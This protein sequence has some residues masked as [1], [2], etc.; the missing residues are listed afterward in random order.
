MQSNEK[1]VAAFL[2]SLPA[3]EKKCLNALRKAVKKGAPGALESMTYG[4]PTYQTGGE[5]V[6]AFN[7][8]KNYLCLYVD[9]K[10]LD[11][12]RAKFKSPKAGKCCVRF[13]LKNPVPL[14]LAEE[15][16]RASAAL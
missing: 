11:P 16:V 9:S 3:A 15:M 2:K 8:Q 1:T 4:M 10:A 13:T 7:M 6:C 12:H 14:D 5:M